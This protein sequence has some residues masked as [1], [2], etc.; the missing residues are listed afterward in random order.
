MNKIFITVATIIV[1]AFS[2]RCGV[3]WVIRWVIRR[4]I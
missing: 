1:T 2:M 3:Q 4:I